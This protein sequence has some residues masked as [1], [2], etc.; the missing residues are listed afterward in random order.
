MGAT[1]GELLLSRNS[2]STAQAND[3]YL[4]RAKA[5]P[6]LS[7]AQHRI[8]ASATSALGDES[9]T[10]MKQLTAAMGIGPA[11]ALVLTGRIGAS[12]TTAYDAFLLPVDVATLSPISGTRYGD[13][14]ARLDP[15]AVTPRGRGH[16]RGHALSALPVSVTAPCTRPVAVHC[17]RA[18]AQARR[19]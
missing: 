5:N 16:G 8:G 4:V 9:A 12:G 3:I 15:E 2:F 7:I 14:G 1:T 6:C 10:D 19:S 17:V 11:G 13:L 18:P